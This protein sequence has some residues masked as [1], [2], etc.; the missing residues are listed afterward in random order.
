MKKIHNPRPSNLS[1]L[2]LLR[3][4][5]PFST[6]PRRNLSI[7]ISSSCASDPISPPARPPLT[8]RPSPGVTGWEEAV[9]GCNLLTPSSLPP[10]NPSF[11]KKHKYQFPITSVWW[12][13]QLR[14]DYITAERNTL[15]ACVFVNQSINP[16]NCVC[17]S[18][19]WRR[20]C[21]HMSASL[22]VLY[23]LE[24][25]KNHLEW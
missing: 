20:V 13:Q 7:F 9:Q 12:R 1:H 21:T 6:F 18:S 5:F 23:D 17:F 25:E 10:L 14:P 24:S 16:S 19:L 11:L 2:H 22:V 15:S 8:S 4:C 3:S